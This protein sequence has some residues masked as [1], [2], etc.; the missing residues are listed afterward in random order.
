MRNKRNIPGL[1]LRGKIWW[2]DKVIHGQR[3]QEST[4]TDDRAEAERYLIYKLEQLRQAKVYGV[5]PKRTFAQAAAKYLKEKKKKTLC[6]DIIHLDSLMPYISED[7]IEN[8]HM[9]NPNLIKF[10]EERQNGKYAELMKKQGKRVKKVATNQTINHALKLIR[11][12]LNLCAKKWRDENNLTWLHAVPMIELL[13]EQEE[14]RKAIPLSWAEQ[15]VL[16]AE[17]SP[18]LRQMTT[19]AVNTGCR[20]REICKLLWEWEI[21]IPALN[22]SVFV[23]PKY[24]H[25]NKHDRLVVLNDIA[26]AVLE[27][28][29]GVDPVYVFTSKPGK[30]YWT[31]GSTSWKKGR[32]RAGLPNVRVHDLKHT[33]GARLTNAG[34]SLE[35]K[36][37]LLGHK[38]SVDISTHYSLASIQNLIES[39]NKVCVRRDDISVA[40]FLKQLSASAKDKTRN[41]IPFVNN[42]VAAK[43]NQSSSVTLNKAC[44][45]SYNSPT[46]SMQGV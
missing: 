10:I 40:G 44:T 33:F 2:I 28:V 27:E 26:K 5:R 15:D 25:K 18:R 46:V 42:V 17:L 20:N 43:N 37:Q 1:R 41:V 16:F 7:A 9:G 23:I 13:D 3:V 34:V 6:D 36:K 45:D 12:I 14:K 35:I 21:P 19:F 8:I 22:T 32:K 29:R 24:A 39:A 30:S 38:G 11:H 4:G 31:M